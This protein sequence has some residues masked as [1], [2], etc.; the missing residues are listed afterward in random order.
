MKVACIVVANEM[1][2]HFPNEDWGKS[3]V[4][5]YK[6][7]RPPSFDFL[8]QENVRETLCPRELQCTGTGD[9]MNFKM[10]SI[11]RKPQHIKSYTDLSLL[12]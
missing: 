4:G 10:L 3:F 5:N 11:S 7:Q 12:H 9:A 2:F 6:T 1:F 8:M